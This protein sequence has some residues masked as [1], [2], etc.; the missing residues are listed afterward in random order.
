MDKIIKHDGDGKL[1]YIDSDN[2]VHWVIEVQICEGDSVA[3]AINSLLQTHQERPKEEGKFLCSEHGNTFYDCEKCG[4][5]KCNDDSKQLKQEE[6]N[7]DKKEE[8]VFFHTCPQC[9][10]ENEHIEDNDNKCWRCGYS[11]KLQDEKKDSFEKNVD[12]YIE[13]FKKDHPD[14][15]PKRDAVILKDQPKEQ[16]WSYERLDKAYS[17]LNMN[18]PDSPEKKAVWDEKFKDYPYKS[19]NESDKFREIVIR[20]QEENPLNKEEQIEETEEYIKG[21]Q[22]GIEYA[23]K[24]AGE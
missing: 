11:I 13:E 1:Y 16:T 20:L 4:C 23:N 18:W 3:N 7:T 15:C 14:Y 9:D 2:K 21:W 12:N 17:E 19:T 8:M 24:G 5:P 22:D 6:P 10:N